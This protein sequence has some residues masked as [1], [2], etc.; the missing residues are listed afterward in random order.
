M[1]VPFDPQRLEIKGTPVPVVEG[2][3]FSAGYGSSQYSISDYRFVGLRFGGSQGNQRRMVWV[4]RNGA[5]QPLP[6]P[7]QAYEIVRGFPRTDGA[8]RWNSTEQFWLY[9]L[10][11][12]TLTRFTFEGKRNQNPRVDA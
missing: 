3:A 6:A 9:D 12:D 10:A 8:S 7:P 4:S 11:R 2:V 5:E 1:A